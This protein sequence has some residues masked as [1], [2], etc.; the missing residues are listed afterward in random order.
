VAAAVLLAVVLADPGAVA[1]EAAPRAGPV[2]FKAPAQWQYTAPLISPEDRAVDRSMAQ[3]DPS[4]VFAG[5]R[6]HVFMTI[7]LPGMTPM[8]YCSFDRWE[9]ADKAPRTLLKVADSTYYCAPQVFYFTPQQKWYLMY[10]LGVPGRKNMHI[11]FS[12]TADIADPTSWSKAQ[13]IFESDEAD[14]RQEGGLDYWVICDEERA[15]LFFTSLNGKLWRM[16][17][18]LEDFPHGFGHLEV[19]LRA[20]IFEAS[21]TYR[22]KGL[23][24]YLTIVEANAGG[25]RYYKAYLA[26]SLDGAWT[27]V[28]DSEQ[29]P[30]AGAVNVVPAASVPAWTDNISHGELIREGRDQTMTVDPEQ[31]RFVF[32]GALEKEKAGKNYSQIPWRIGILTPAR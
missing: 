19:A 29:K 13:S 23:N 6:W 5:G 1:Q 4:V 15:Y 10:Q 18:R 20:D 9:D 24:K 12:T 7:K 22:L 31:L 21:H 30:F 2:E 17:T 25:K 26:D 28:A 8:E 11:A 32:Q 3:K 14:P 27:P 16:W